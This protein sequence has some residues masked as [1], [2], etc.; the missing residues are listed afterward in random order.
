LQWTD[1]WQLR[2]ENYF[3]A[4]ADTNCTAVAIAETF[5][6][7]ASFQWQ[8]ASL[9]PTQNDHSAPSS[10]LSAVQFSGKYAIC[11]NIAAISATFATFATF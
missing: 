6:A 11:A 5:A 3:I 8:H 7:F 2:T 10:L 9:P 1:N 4:A